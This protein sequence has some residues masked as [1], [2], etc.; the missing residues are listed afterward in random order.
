MSTTGLIKLAHRLGAFIIWTLVPQ[1]NYA[2]FDFSY[3]TPIDLDR[4]SD[5]HKEIS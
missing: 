2:H 5:E 1:H 4:A 3:S